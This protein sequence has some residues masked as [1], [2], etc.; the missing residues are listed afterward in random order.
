MTRSGTIKT[1]DIEWIKVYPN[2]KRLRNNKLPT[3]LKGSGGDIII[4]GPIFLRNLKPCCHLKSNGK[5][6]CKPLYS[7]YLMEW[8]NPPTDLCVS[9]T[10]NSLKDNC[11]ETVAIIVD[12]NRISPINC[13]S[14][15]KYACNRTVIG[16]KEGR[17]AY[18][19]TETNYTPEG[20]RELLISYGWSYAIML[21]G[22]GSSCIWFS[23]GTGIIGSDPKRILP[24]FIVVKLKPVVDSEPKGAKPMTPISVY[25]L[26]KDGK[27]Y[28][29][30]NFQVKEFRCGDGTDPVFVAPALVAVLQKIR[31][32]YRKGVIITS[33]YRTPTHNQKVGG[34]TYSQHIYGTAADFYIKGVP[35][36]EIAA[37]ARSIMPTGGVGIYNK[38]G[39]VHVDVREEVANW[40]E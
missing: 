4:S 33:G 8:N 6:L 28:I 15:M 38:E 22:G 2:T 31:D 23:D 21:D 12:G 25:S 35:V 13:G 30:K 24:Y 9:H 3:L 10:N 17:F 7:T 40:S 32:H 37:Y 19:V 16:I 26:R 39:F 34:V 5:Y 36:A 29:S 27:K 14:D 11:I 20:L 1:E 18:L